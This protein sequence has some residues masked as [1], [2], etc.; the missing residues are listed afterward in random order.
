M[1]LKLLAIHFI[2]IFLLSSCSFLDTAFEEKDSTIGMTAGELYEEGKSFL[3]AEDFINAIRVFEILEA[4]YPFGK[5]STQAM[6]DLSYAHYASGNKESA[7]IEA[8]RFIR[9]Y[10]NHSQV[11][12]AYYLKAL[13]NF[14]KDANVLTR[15]FAHDPSRYDITNLKNSFNDFTIIVNRFPNSLYAEDAI[16]RLRYIKNQIAKNELYIAKYYNKRSAHVA[17][18]NRIQYMLE[19]YGGT[20]STKGGLL[21]MVDSYNKMKMF[22]LAYDAARVLKKNYPNYKIVKNSDRTISILKPTKKNI[23]KENN[24]NKNEESWWDYLNIFNWI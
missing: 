12:Y 2:L 6:L 13:S 19:N 17:A 10:P 20:P 22:D 8:N 18:V 14:D 7:I 16:N 21:L 4:R 24:K 1:K 3:S 11:S 9:L 23:K 15:F 5:H